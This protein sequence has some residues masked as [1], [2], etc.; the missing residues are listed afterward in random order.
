MSDKVMEE[1]DIGE[2]VITINYCQNDK[3]YIEVL[4]ELGVK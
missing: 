1:V 3:V 4:G 2:Y